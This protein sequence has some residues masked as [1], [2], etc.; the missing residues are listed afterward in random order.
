[1]RPE[2]DECTMADQG[3]TEPDAGGRERIGIPISAAEF[4]RLVEHYLARMESGEEMKPGDYVT[5]TRL[6]NTIE[7]GRL[8]ERDEI[9]RHYHKGFFPEYVG[10]VEKALHALPTKGMALYSKEYDL[11]LGGK[12]HANSSYRIE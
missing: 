2:L 12:P 5:M 1:M 4:R 7:R 10:R 9:F 11:F 6:W 8:V 3:I